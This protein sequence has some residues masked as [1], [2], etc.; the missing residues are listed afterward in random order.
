MTPTN[1][2]LC[3]KKGLLLDL[4]PKEFTLRRM[5]PATTQRSAWCCAEVS[6]VTV[7][8]EEGQ[9]VR[10]EI[11][12]IRLD[13]SQPLTPFVVEF[14]TGHG[15]AQAAGVRAGWFLDFEATLQSSHQGLA[16]L[17]GA[18]SPLPDG[19]GEMYGRLEELHGLFQ[20]MLS[21]GASG[22][23]LVFRNGVE[24]ELLPEMRV[25][26][27]SPQTLGDDVARFEASWLYAGNF[28]PQG[29]KP[30]GPADAASI[31]K[32]WWVDISQTCLLSP[33]SKMDPESWTHPEA[34]AYLSH[35]RGRTDVT[36]VFATRSLDEHSGR[37]SLRRCCGL[38]RD[39]P[40]VDPPPHTGN[41][42]SAL[43]VPGGSAQVEFGP[44]EDP[45]ALGYYGWGVR[46]PHLEGAWGVFAVALPGSGEAPDPKALDRLAEAWRALEQGAREPSLVVERDEWCE[47]R[48]RALCQRH[49]WEFEWMSFDGEGQKR[50]V[51]HAEETERRYVYIHI[52]IYI[53][54]YM[55]VYV[56]AYISLSLY[57][58]IYID[59]CI[60]VYTNIHISLSLSIYIYIYTYIYSVHIYIY[61]YIYIWQIPQTS[62]N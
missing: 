61:I 58:Y 60:Y 33:G 12:E 44:M 19:L 9:E 17:W 28:V 11:G 47:E 27:R 21:T 39:W 56:Y 41:N 10:G 46:P 2:S 43:K 50:I 25:S 20:A 24:A 62:L 8:Y 23:T 29:L 36:L 14:G 40:S 37:S 54:I 1:Y 45:G 59:V 3:D 30:G 53:Y 34:A 55:Y 51:L 18:G 38:L 49:G 15:P 57:I 42:F 4:Q 13:L 5:L 32:G 6:R 7:H 35:L 52:H 48:L 31:S 26:Y 16:S 22:V